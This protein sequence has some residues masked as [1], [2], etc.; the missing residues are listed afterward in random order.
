MKEDKRN[1][2]IEFKHKGKNALDMNVSYCLTS[3]PI[4]ED[5]C[6]Q[7]KKEI[8]KI[9]NEDT[10]LPKSDTVVEDGIDLGFTIAGHWKREYD[11]L[12]SEVDAIRA[13]TWKAARQLTMTDFHHTPYS[14]RAFSDYLYS[15]NLNSN[16]TGK[17]LSIALYSD[18]NI[19]ISNKWE[20]LTYE[21]RGILYNIGK[22]GFYKSESGDFFYKKVPLYANQ[23]SVKRNSDNYIFT[24]GDIRVKDGANIKSIHLGTS[25]NELSYDGFS[26]GIEYCGEHISPIKSQPV[27]EDNVFTLPQQKEIQNIIFNQT[28]YKPKG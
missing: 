7:L 14:Y 9:L 15:L 10:P 17:E 22:D 2:V 3:F 27:V 16:D 5:K 20:I 21:V 8:E 28:G 19:P 25:L 1:Y 4:P 6:Q 13:D 18:R 11:K 23:Y 12:K 24:V 26:Q